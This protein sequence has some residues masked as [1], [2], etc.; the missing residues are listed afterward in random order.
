MFGGQ[1]STIRNNILAGG[2]LALLLLAVLVKAWMLGS[3]TVRPADLRSVPKVKATSAVSKGPPPDPEP[4]PI[5][6]VLRSGEL[7][8]ISKKSQQ[9]FVFKNGVLWKTSPVSTGRRG[10]TTPSGVFAILQKAVRHRSNK[11]SNAPMPYMQRLTW[12]GVAMHA[13]RLPGYAAS[14]GCIRL[15][16]GFA[17]ELYAQTNAATTTIVI[18]DSALKTDAAARTL[19]LNMPMPRPRVPAAIPDAPVTAL[20]QAAI[21]PQSVRPVPPPAAIVA[22]TAAA[23]PTTAP[24]LPAPTAVAHGPTIQLAAADSAANAEAEWAR[25]VT[26]HPELRSFQRRIEPA[27]VNARQVFRLRATAANAQATCSALR[28]ANVP[29]FSVN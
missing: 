29:C 13:G 16:H 5:A 20:V 2:A 6:E 23:V 10:H 25:L 14:H 4:R 21:P 11:Y 27:T 8:V 1:N 3:G 28:A 17:R 19:A 24:V 22:A 9:M 15:P 18:T 7:I 12:D 26:A